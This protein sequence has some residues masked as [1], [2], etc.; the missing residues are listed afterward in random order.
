MVLVNLCWTEGQLSVMCNSGCVVRTEDNKYIA[1]ISAV[2][3][4]VSVFLKALDGCVMIFATSWLFSRSRCIT[5]NSLILTMFTCVVVIVY[6]WEAFQSC[7][8]HHISLNLVDEFFSSDDNKWSSMNIV[9]FTHH[10]QIIMLI[11]KCCI[12]ISDPY[13][14]IILIYVCLWCSLQVV[15]ITI[16]CWSIYGSILQNIF[17][18][19]MLCMNYLKLFLN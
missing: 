14:Q 12:S 16:I 1:A 3:L 7:R 8:W 6:L 9:H 4:A 19:L 2:C 15:D 11:H 18:R 10:I 13:L 5:F 17:N